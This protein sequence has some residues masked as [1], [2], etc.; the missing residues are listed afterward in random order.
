M[1]WLAESGMNFRLAAGLTG[2]QPMEIRR[3][4]VVNVFFGSRDLPEPELQLKAFIANLGVTAIVID[5]SDPR[6]PQ[7]KEL[8]ASLNLTPMEV[9]GVLLYRIP[10]DPLKSYLGITALEMEQRAE[11]TRFQTLIAAADRYLVNGGSADNLDL[12]TLESAG[13]FP[14]GWI[15][16]PK[17]KAYHDIWTGR[18][19]GKIA[20]GV[21]G[22]ASGLKPIIDGYGAGADKIYFPFP[23]VWPPDKD[24]RGFVSW[25]FEPAIWGST[26][27]ESIQLMVMEFAPPQLR[28]LDARLAA[29]SSAPWLSL[30]TVPREAS[31]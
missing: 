7:W 2:L 28:Q 31:R 24:Y 15:F 14:A 8:L 22:T 25:L 29:E 30:A 1:M 13:L 9:S 6:V 21:G 10:P 12:M 3:W 4:P 19:E 26:S 27:G 18:L 16:N 5:A 17:R 11:R 20:I 23:R